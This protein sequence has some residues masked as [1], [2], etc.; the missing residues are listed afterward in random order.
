MSTTEPALT[1]HLV[2]SDI[3]DNDQLLQRLNKELH[4]LFGIE[5]MTVQLELETFECSQA[6]KRFYI[7]CQLSKSKINRLAPPFDNKIMLNSKSLIN[8]R[9]GLLLLMAHS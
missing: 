2:R 1:V 7:R 9:T 8:S 3:N 6:Q 5:H 4:D